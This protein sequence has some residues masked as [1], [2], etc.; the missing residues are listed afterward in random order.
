M[1]HHTARFPIFPASPSPLALNTTPFK[2]TSPAVPL[3]PVVGLKWRKNHEGHNTHQSARQHSHGQRNRPIPARRRQKPASEPGTAP[4]K[5]RTWNSNLNGRKWANQDTCC[6]DQP[7]IT[8]EP[9]KRRGAGPRFWLPPPHLAATSVP[10]RSSF[11]S[12]GGEEAFVVPAGDAAFLAGRRP[13]PWDTDTL[14]HPPS[15]G[16]KFRPAVRRPRL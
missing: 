9:V 4:A 5:P 10:T 7:I 14:S 6:R 3:G 15:T 1:P 11:H 12:V 2:R 13:C 16:G 8:Q